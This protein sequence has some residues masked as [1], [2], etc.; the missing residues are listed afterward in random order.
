VNIL[1]E[2]YK[3]HLEKYIKE[4]ELI[5]PK[6][7]LLPVI[8]LFF[9]YILSSIAT[10]FIIIKICNMQNYQWVMHLISFVAFFFVFAKWILIKSV[11]CY[12]HYASEELRRCCTC[13]P[14]CSEYAIAVLKKYNLFKALSKI[15][16]RL[17]KKCGG[18]GFIQ[19]E[20]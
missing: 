14:S 13:I 3:K 20:P 12:Q 8:L 7:T 15:R 4:R 18:W 9:G 1:E 17:F 5:R 10:A 2:E 16:I 19:D 11:E 6:T